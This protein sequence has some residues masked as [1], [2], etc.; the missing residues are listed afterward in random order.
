MNKPLFV[1]VNLSLRR[2]SFQEMSDKI[3]YAPFHK[4]Q[5]TD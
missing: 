1:K 5:V 3:P 2:A 4:L